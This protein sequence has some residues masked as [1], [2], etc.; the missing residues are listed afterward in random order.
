V[1]TEND[2]V[3]EDSPR[4]CPPAKLSRNLGLSLVPLWL[5]ILVLGNSESVKPFGAL[6]FFV[7]V[8]AVFTAFFAG[9]I[10]LI[11]ISRSQGTLTGAGMAGLGLVLTVAGFVICF[12]WLAPMPNLRGT[13]QRNVCTTN[14]RQIDGARQEWALANQK[15]P[16]DTP[17]ASDIAPYLKNNVLPVC[18]SGGSYTLNPLSA[19]PVC[20]KAALGHTL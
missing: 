11:R 19:Q 13:A 12:S 16:S 5:L 8:G 3:A 10:A 2:A 1:S 18:P 4:L 7:W 17:S 14:L 15:T 20:S 6:L 9:V